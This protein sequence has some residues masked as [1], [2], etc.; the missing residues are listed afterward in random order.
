MGKNDANLGTD[1]KTRMVC[2]YLAGI[3]FPILLWGNSLSIEQFLQFKYP[4]TVAISPDGKQF[5][6]TIREA[7]FERNRWHTRLWHLAAGDLEFRQF[8]HSNANDR[9]PR[10][11][12][13]GEWISFLSDRNSAGVE[14]STQQIWAMPSGGGEP[15]RWSDARS[16]VRDYRWAADGST[17]V[18][19][20]EQPVP[21]EL[22]EKAEARSKKGFDATVRDSLSVPLT[23]W[24]LDAKTGS[25]VQIATLDA[26]VREFDLSPDGKWI[27]Y[28]TNYSGAYDDEQKFDLWALNIESGEKS[29]LTNFP[30]PEYSPK[31]S[32]D[33]QWIFY[34][35]QTTP[36]IEFAETDV[37]RLRFRPG[38]TLPD[39]LTLTR[40]FDWS[41]SDFVVEPGSKALILEVAQGLE[42][43]LYR[44]RYLQKK[45]RYIRISDPGVNAFQP[46]FSRNGV[47]S[48]LQETSSTLPE[49]MVLRDKKN[50]RLSDFSRQLQSFQFGRQS[51]FEW[52]SEGNATIEGLLVLPVDFDPGKKYPLI[53]TVHG[54]PYGRFRNTLRQGYY[55][56]IYANNGFVLLAPNPRGSSGYDDAFGKAI[57]YKTGGH[58]GGVDYRD[59]MNGVDALI[60]KGFVDTSRM[61]VIGGS[62][63]G[64]MTNWIISQ[65]HRFAAAVSQFGIFSLFTDWSNSWQP[66]WEKMYLGIYYWEQPISA[67]HPYVK[68]SPAFYVQ[69][70]RTPVLIL[71]GER[72]RYT[73]LANSQEMYQALKTLNREVKF[74]V[75]PR[76]GHGLGSEPNHRRDVFHRSLKWFI[77]HLKP[78][79]KGT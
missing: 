51:V 75:Y 23:F 60:K 40:D 50:V 6:F 12:P 29:Q 20:S 62:Y 64:Y 16:G 2:L 31:F 39:T 53:L 73:N 49:I 33:G 14:E 22:K 27:V 4:E 30:G 17:I 63:G 48:F 59:I 72:D 79:K 46:R 69:H 58:M 71:H 8:T 68:Y 57:W 37:A 10:W 21:P 38:S 19:L 13:D 7:D 24:R 11:S 1:L 45:N 35:N 41:I 3:L 78:G 56:Q 77:Q 18:F 5:V 15:R 67:D 54:G 26:G 52:Q 32:A 44:F 61:G 9:Q 47:L 65:N 34:R 25:T 36:D 42:T 76:E 55:H 70:I 74:V 43:H 66:S 28:E